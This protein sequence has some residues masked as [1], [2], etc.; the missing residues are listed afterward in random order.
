MI[1][2][3]SR[4]KSKKEVSKMFYFFGNNC[5]TDCCS[6]WQILRKLCGFGC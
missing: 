1:A 5:G 4:D 2:P 3:S 6:I